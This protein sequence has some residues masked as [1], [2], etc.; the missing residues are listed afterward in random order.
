[1]RTTVLIILLFVF[2]G[3][4][5]VKAAWLF[6]TDGSII[7][8]KI[9]RQT[10]TR[11]TIKM[12]EGG[13]RTIEGN[14]ILRI[15][16][17]NVVKK[18]VYLHIRSDGS[19]IQSNI[20]DETALKIITRKSIASPDE[21]AYKKED[22]II[23][24]KRQSC[25]IEGIAGSN[26]ISLEWNRSE[27]D[28]T[29]MIYTAKE[30][31][32]FVCVDRTDREQYIIKGLSGST[33]YD[34]MI[35]IID[36]EGTF[37]VSETPVR[38]ATGNVRPAKP[39]NLRCTKNSKGGFDLSWDP[40]TDGDGSIA[41]YRVYS[42]K[43]TSRNLIGSPDN[44]AFTFPMTADGEILSLRVSSVDNK[45]TESPLSE[46]VQSRDSRIADFGFRAAYFMPVRSLRDR[47]LYGYGAS[48]TAGRRGLFVR[49]SYVGVAFGGIRFA[50]KSDRKADLFSASV[51]AGYTHDIRGMFSIAGL[52]SAGAGNYSGSDNGQSFQRHVPVM[53][54]VVSPGFRS[55]RG[56]VY[57]SAGCFSFVERGK[58]RCAP[59]V[60]AG[61]TV[62]LER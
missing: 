39:E 51:E 62:S 32:S 19:L 22:V 48:F 15:R 6:K 45:G 44:E 27:N 43:G 8:G 35:G 40:S 2:F 60:S 55:G 14:D 56:F 20:V 34:V 16:E 52:L 12:K 50:G 42:V 11:V 1:M 46:P 25:V 41:G 30:G 33:V 4:V 37:R 10:A 26:D 21:V 53:S 54:A 5:P 17:K 59:V 28:R 47:Y 18:E 38:F 49:G 31:H 3:I 36:S 24:E 9:I 13:V 7:E 57:L 61:V 23:A 58:F 29:Y